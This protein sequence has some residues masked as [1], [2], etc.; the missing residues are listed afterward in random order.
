MERTIL[1]CRVGSH[2]YGL[3]TPESDEDFAEIY[4]C[5]TDEIFGLN[6]KEHDDLDKDYRRY[7]IGKFIRLLVNGNPNMLEILNCPPEAIVSKTEGWDY[8][9]Q[10]KHLFV[11]KKLY[12]TFTGYATSQIHKAQ[13]L[14]KKINWEEDK[15]ERKDV[16]DFCWI[17]PRDVFHTS[18]IPVKKWLQT[19]GYKQEDCGLA[20][21]DHF[22]DDYW[23]YHDVMKGLVSDNPR[24]KDIPQ[25]FHYKGI[26]Q[27][28]ENSN[29]IS[30]SSIPSYAIPSGIMRFAKDAYSVH[31][32]EYASYQKWL[33]ERNDVRYN[34]NKKHAQP[35]D[36]KN[37]MH[38][39]RLLKLSY[40]I[41]DGIVNVVPD[42][43]EKKYLLRIK[44]GEENLVEVLVQSQALSEVV[45]VKFL[46]SDLPD[47]VDAVKANQ[48]LVALR[49]ISLFNDITSESDSTCGTG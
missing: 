16:L 33:L 30:L 19:E 39:M 14:N 20:K 28:I 29:D 32:K 47:D 18:G 3:N 4:I 34:T 5:D 48:L 25:V 24:F 40:R 49:N 2:M 45:R 35:Y 42:E 31:C 11:T 15:K 10:Y 37:I 7:E 44:S 8:L 43:D 27:D 46:E 38:L 22:G 17:L 1:K 26:V 23:L 13:G 12:E 36:S 21:I 41:A 6:Y 9:Q